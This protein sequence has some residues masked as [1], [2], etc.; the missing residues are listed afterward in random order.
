M[1]PPTMPP[2]GK[3]KSL[4]P[5]RCGVGEGM[6]VSKSEFEPQGDP[7]HMEMCANGERVDGDTEL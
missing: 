1:W 3:N 2:M 5:L 7:E 4:L 6:G